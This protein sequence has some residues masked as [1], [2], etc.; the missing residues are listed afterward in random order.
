MKMW[1]LVGSAGIRGVGGRV[2][3]WVCTGVGVGV[4]VG[5]GAGVGLGMRSLWLWLWVWSG[6]ASVGVSEG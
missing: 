2:G 6:V 3:L 1:D 4:G 5:V